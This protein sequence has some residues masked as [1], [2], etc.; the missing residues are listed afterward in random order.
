MPHYIFHLLISFPV[1]IQHY[2][3][4][5]AK[6]YVISGNDALMTCSVPSHVAD[7]VSVISWVDSEGAQ[8]QAGSAT[9][10]HGTSLSRTFSHRVSHSFK[11]LV[12]RHNVTIMYNSCFTV[13]SQRYTTHV[14]QEYVIAGNDVLFKCGVPSHLADLVTVVSWEDS[15]GGT[16]LTSSPGKP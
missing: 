7:F 9:L 3:T 14:S 8:I 5:V 2:E 6:E 4:D 15:D 13:V 12:V 11:A 10:S 1:V 16:F